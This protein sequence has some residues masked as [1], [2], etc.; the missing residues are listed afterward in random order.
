MQPKSF[1]DLSILDRQVF[2][3]TSGVCELFACTPQT[4]SAYVRKGLL[5]PVVLPGQRA[6]FYA[7]SDIKACIRTLNTSNEGLA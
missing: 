7:T 4:L 5:H 2:L 3:A 1:V 6:N